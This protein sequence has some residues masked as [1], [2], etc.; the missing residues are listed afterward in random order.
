MVV[1]LLVERNKE[2]EVGPVPILLIAHVVTNSVKSSK[3]MYF[4]GTE[5]KKKVITLSVHLMIE[6]G[7]QH[8][9]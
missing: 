4:Y 6:L 2:R 3:K 5:R 9:V 8:T 7:I 1:L